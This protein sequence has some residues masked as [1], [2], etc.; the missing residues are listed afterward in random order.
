MS[1]SPLADP[2]S[3][4]PHDRVSA[5]L[6]TRPVAGIHPLSRPKVRPE[7]ITP[8]RTKGHPKSRL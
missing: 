3:M 4:N 6:E 1:G 5:R 8:A 7:A 2:S